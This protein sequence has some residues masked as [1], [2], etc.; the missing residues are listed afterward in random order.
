M[1]VP[2]QVPGPSV[3]GAGSAR[4]VRAIFGTSS[5]RR[6][7]RSTSRWRTTRRTNLHSN[8]YCHRSPTTR[9]RAM[10][11]PA[12]VAKTTVSDRR[13]S[14]RRFAHATRNATAGTSTSGMINQVEPG[15][16]QPLNGSVP[17][18]LPPSPGRGSPRGLPGPPHRIGRLRGLRH[19]SAVLEE[20][21]DPIEVPVGSVCQLIDARRYPDREC[22]RH[23]AGGSPITCKSP[24]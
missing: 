17:S 3:H 12:S 20:L 22:R 7:P 8:R 19:L 21:D 13:C 4:T 2:W 23:P 14:S 6:S 5:S 18:P 10:N 11:P 16:I 24:P 9:V 15:L 1:T